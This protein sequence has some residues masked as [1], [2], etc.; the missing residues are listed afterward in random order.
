MLV[1]ITFDRGQVTISLNRPTFCVPVSLLN[2]NEVPSDDVAACGVIY[3][4]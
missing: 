1:I 4:S 3:D 2:H